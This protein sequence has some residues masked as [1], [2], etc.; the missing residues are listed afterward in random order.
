MS[1]KKIL[2]IA[3]GIVVL[4]AVGVALGARNG[5]KGQIRVQIE[6]IAARR[7]VQTVTATGRIQ[8]VTQVNIS[9]DVSAK[10]TR[11]EVEEGDWVEKGKF[12]LELDRERYLAEVE[13][14][15][16]NLR[17]AQS[18]AKAVA[19][20]LV[21]AEKDL[22]RSRSLFE[23]KL[24]PQA[25]LDAAVASA[26]A[27]RA[28]HRS[29]VDQAEQSRAALKQARDALSKTSIYAPMSGTVSKLNKEVGEIALGSQF[30]EDV[31]LELSNLTGME[32]LVDVDENDIVQLALGDEATIEVDALPGTT[33]KGEVTE[34]ASSAK[35]SAQGTAEQKTEFEVKIAIT[36]PGAQLRPGMTA[37]ADV[38]TEVRESVPAVPIQ[39]VAVR[40]PEQL[41]AQEG[42]GGND[43]DDGD[44]AGNAA[45]EAAP[46][47]TPDKEGFVQVVFVV[48]DGVAKA[49]QVKTGI[50][51]DTHIELL[52]GPAA[53][54]QVVI[55]S[56]RAISRDLRDGS[57]VVVGEAEDERGGPG[58]GRDSGRAGD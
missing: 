15:E 46:A 35:T 9:A 19:E 55:G 20:T 45:A 2:W 38:V 16:A 11:L 22:E 27:E 37:S 43:G 52:E 23:Q 7:V 57:K 34:I 24:E 53:G 30:Q 1:K 48:T 6:P 50:Q 32:A 56:Y 54:E 49:R 21:K 17:A 18:Q 42:K 41:G 29:S 13:S 10:I 14:A 40:T 25:A 8:P 12:L 33:F 51:S 36:E 4:A 31:I 39:S 3:G 28:R 5:R 44:D 26:E 47:F 58:G